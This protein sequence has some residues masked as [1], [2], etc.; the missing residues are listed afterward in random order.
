MA[1][2]HLQ[3]G[4]NFHDLP[5]TLKTSRIC[6]DRQDMAG[7]HSCRNLYLEILPSIYEQGTDSSCSAWEPSVSCFRTRTAGGGD[8]FCAQGSHVNHCTGA[9]HHCPWPGLCPGINTILTTLGMRGDQC[10]VSRG[11]A[12][13]IC[14]VY[15]G[16]ELAQGV[17]GFREPL[18]G[19]QEGTRF[20]LP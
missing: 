16:V 4:D 14:E 2:S 3:I 7:L 15:C 19:A 18:Q 11:K 6:S 10:A 1:S 12:G 20:H 13:R 8:R 17:H 9:T 5:S